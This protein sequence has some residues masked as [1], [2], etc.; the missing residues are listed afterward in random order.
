MGD[1][2]F[3]FEVWPTEY[4]VITQQF[5][6]NPHNY[7]QFGL[8]GHDGIDIRARTGTKIYC[9]APGEVSMADNDPRGSAY[10]IH[11][12]VSHQE[13][14]LTIYAHLQKTVVHEG[15]RVEA[16]T[17]LGL[18]DST[19]NSTGSHLH[20]GLRK[21]GSNY[22]NWPY[23]IVDP[24]PF[25]LPLLGWKE[26]AGPYVEGWV[27]DNGITLKDDLAQVS[28]GGATLYINENLNVLMPGGTLLIVLSHQD[29]FTRV[30][31]PSV[32]V[33]IKDST[34]PTPAPE[35]PPIVSTVDGW[36]WEPFLTVVGRQAI[37]GSHGIFLRPSPERSALP[38]GFVKAGSTVSVSGDPIGRY[39]LVRV[40]RNDFEE[41]VVLPDPPPDPNAIPPESGYLG[42]VLTQ[43][44]SP[45]DE[46][47]ALTSRLG[48]NL[49][50]RP[51]SSGQNFGLV[52]AFATVNIAGEERGKYTPVLIREED[53]LNV[54][55]PLPEIELPDSEPDGEPTPPPPEP[56]PAA[57]PGWS[58]TNGLIITEDETKVAKYGSNLRAAPRRGAEKIG[59]IPADTVIMVTGP[60]QGE[61]TPVR[62]DA[63][64]LE[65]PV[66]DDV[67]DPDPDTQTL[68]QARI[69]LHASADP[70]IN[71]AEH[72][73]FTALRPGMIKVLSFHSADDI[74][75]L[76]ANHKD[77][78]W[79]VR[80]FLSFGGRHISPA[81]FVYDT[82]GDVRRAL[83]KLRGRE[84]VVELH[85]EPNLVAEG[86]GTSWTDGARFNIWWR[87]LL[88]KYRLALPG[89]RFIYPGLSPGST[90]VGIRLDHIQFI[91][92]SRQAVA[93]ADGL[94][95]HTYWSNVYPMSRSLEVVDDYISR[96]PAKPIWITEAS[97]N[98]D[99]IPPTQM[100][101]EYLNFWHEL[102]S[103]STIKGIT[104]F[105]ASASDPVF[106]NEVWVGKGIG[107]LVGKR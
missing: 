24:T 89:V 32:A 21:D 68:G 33:G 8:P 18:A 49:R 75:R 64:L 106:G 70:D 107:A 44:L 62:V 82:I 50:S 26:P 103:R 102:Q 35:P 94:A 57:I 34:T 96:F 11:V 80:A 100:A 101:Q 86:L 17:L 67:E 29:P 105:V 83:T 15:Q 63:E 92:A 66:G 74:G 53:V 88:K 39:A 99:S 51:D 85:N 1:S 47:Q 52:K 14:Y 91:E 9:V 37:V 56:K 84:V 2:D 87:E 23:D 73:E 38:I 20:L 98:Q 10:G 7:A 104:Y 45:I 97:H 55:D 31:V 13:G 58:F 12:R 71:D 30:R 41:P 16:G 4:R 61:Y 6:V 19:G 90:I 5:G 48:V 59:F 25:I 40:R 42:W 78:Q 79:V 43:Y 54:A 28:V 60:A 93:E 76:A 46:H 95:I 72:Q 22:K 27:L 69:G 3:K 36:A 65:R 77:A 81:K